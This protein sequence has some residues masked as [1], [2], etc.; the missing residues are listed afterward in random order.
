V[1][2]HSTPVWGVGSIGRGLNGGIN[3][4]RGMRNDE[5]KKKPFEASGVIEA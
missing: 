2:L 1:P 3:D 4:E 5:L